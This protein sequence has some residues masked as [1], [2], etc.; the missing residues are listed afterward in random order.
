MAIGDSHRPFGNLAGSL[1]GRRCSSK[2]K[3]FFPGIEEPH[4]GWGKPDGHIRTCGS[5]MEQP[6]GIGKTAVGDYM[7]PGQDIQSR[8]ALARP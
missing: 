4:V 7:V 1:D 5:D 6:F 8:Q 2:P 3:E